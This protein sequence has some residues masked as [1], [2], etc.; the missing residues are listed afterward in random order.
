MPIPGNVR[1]APSGTVGFDSDTLITFSA[2][3]RF[4]QQ[5]YRFCLR[6]LSLTTQE[7]SGDLSAVGP[8]SAFLGNNAL[9]MLVG[10][11]CLLWAKYGKDEYEPAIVRMLAQ[12]P[13]NLV[14]PIFFSCS[15]RTL[16][17][18]RR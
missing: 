4:A 9:Y 8:T 1:S 12:E 11:I 15:G 18:I 17:R 14:A 3:Q 10:F 6:Y 5:G 16:A 13:Y 7:A 2:A